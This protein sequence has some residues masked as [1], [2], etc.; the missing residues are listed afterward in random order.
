MINAP[1]RLQCN[2][3]HSKQHQELAGCPVDKWR[4]YC[5]DLLWE[6]IGGTLRS[7]VSH[8]RG[9]LP[10]ELA[11][12][13]FQVFDYDQATGNQSYLWLSILC[14]SIYTKY[15]KYIKNSCAIHMTL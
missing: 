9:G 4:G 6:K 8:T 14:C 13:V 11:A 7:Q 5:V 10:P 12:K 3:E 2:D 15:I 1:S